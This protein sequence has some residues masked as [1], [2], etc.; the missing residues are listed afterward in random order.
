MSHRYVAVT[1]RRDVTVHQPNGKLVEVLPARGGET[2][3][4]LTALV[5]GH[6]YAVVGSWRVLEG[7]SGTVRAADLKDA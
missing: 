4:E 3:E 6:G 5:R 7:R 2:P 1:G